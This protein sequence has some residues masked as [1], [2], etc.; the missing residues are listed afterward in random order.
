MLIDPEQCSLIT[1]ACKPPRN[2]D[3][4]EIAPPVRFVWFEEFP[5]VCYS[6]WEDRT[7]CLTDVLFGFKNVGKSLQKAIS[8]ME[9]SCK[10]IK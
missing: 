6:R 4:P 1:N 7:C 10:N 8:N 5:W 2:F 3:F 9:S